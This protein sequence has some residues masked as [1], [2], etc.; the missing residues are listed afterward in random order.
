MT[1][2]ELI[3][4]LRA[5]PGDCA[6]RLVYVDSVNCG[7]LDVQ[8]VRVASPGHVSLSLSDPVAAVTLVV[9]GQ[10]WVSRGPVH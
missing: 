6:L 10:S 2:V 5:L 8:A 4:A 9:D 7:P 3:E 1:V